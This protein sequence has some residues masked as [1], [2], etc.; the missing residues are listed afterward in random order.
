[1][2]VVGTGLAGVGGLHWCYLGL[3]VVCVL[4][5]EPEL[6]VV[7]VGEGVGGDPVFLV[8]PASRYCSTLT[9]PYR[10]AESELAALTQYYCCGDGCVFGAYAGDEGGGPEVE[11]QPL[12][13]VAALGAPAAAGV[14]VPVRRGAAVAG[15]VPLGAARLQLDSSVQHQPHSTA[16]YLRVGDLADNLVALLTTDNVHSQARVVVPGLHMQPQEPAL[17]S[18]VQNTNATL[19][20]K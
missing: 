15:A 13:L 16:Q 5:V 11:L 8:A 7:A 12:V 20:M 3:Q 9:Y 6:G 2:I 18:K 10:D 4:V 19:Q 17:L 1:M 14:D